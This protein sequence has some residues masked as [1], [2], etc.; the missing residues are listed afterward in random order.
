MRLKLWKDGNRLTADFRNPAAILRD[1]RQLFGPDFK[2]CGREDDAFRR[3]DLL[4]SPWS[5]RVRAVMFERSSSDA[6]EPIIVVVVKRSYDYHIGIW[7]AVPAE[8]R[9]PLLLEVVA[10]YRHDCC[11]PPDRAPED[12]IGKDAVTIIRSGLATND[13]I[14]AGYRLAGGRERKALCMQVGEEQ[15]FTILKTAYHTCG[16]GEDTDPPLRFALRHFRDKLYSAAFFEALRVYRGV[17][18]QTSRP[19]TTQGVRGEIDVILWQ[20]L[21]HGHAPCWTNR[22]RDG[23]KSLPEPERCHWRWVFQA[24]AYSPL[25]QPPRHWKANELAVRIGRS[26]C[27]ERLMEWLGQP[28]APR[29]V[30]TWAGSSVLKNVVWLATRLE[31]RPLDAELESVMS[32]PWKND[33]PLEKLVSPMLY[34]R[35]KREIA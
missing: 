25:P 13:F 11:H 17:L 33:R 18:A 8:L 9:L 29:P 30:M 16:H 7:R 5:G 26:L 10:R 21:D 6:D 34:L 24:F 22:L 28:F 14:T 3:V 19:T 20:D 32:L 1:Y 4:T 35:R 23:I 12:L 15:A 27:V 31:H 2:N